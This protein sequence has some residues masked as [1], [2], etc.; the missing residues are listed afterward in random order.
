M[1]D[2]EIIEDIKTSHKYLK[3]GNYT[4]RLRVIDN[5]GAE[6]IDSHKIKIK[7]LEPPKLLP[8]PVINISDLIYSNEIISFSSN[9]SYDPD[10]EIVNY[11]WDFG[12]GNISYLNDTTHIYSK[13]GNYTVSLRVLDN[14]NLSNSAVKIINVLDKTE[15]DKKL[16]EKDQPILFII[17]LILILI[18]TFIAL[19]K[20]QKRFKF[21]LIIEKANDSNKNKAI[22]LFSK[23]YSKITKK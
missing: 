14:D 13:P 9:G 15:K 16:R 8:I 19:Y 23:I 6:T 5:L 21:T 1:F 7:E 10:G 3:T 18:S 17:L 2:T 11:T 20:I 4:V 22:D 12:D